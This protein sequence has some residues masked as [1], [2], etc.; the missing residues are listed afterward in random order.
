MSDTLEQVRPQSNSRV[1]GSTNPCQAPQ[2][3]TFRASNVVFSPSFARRSSDN[4]GIQRNEGA[5]DEMGKNG[6]AIIVGMKPTFVYYLADP[7]TQRHPRYVGM[8]SDIAARLKKHVG[9][10][11]FEYGLLG[12]WKKEVLTAGRI[13]VLIVVAGMEGAL[14]SVVAGSGEGC[15]IATPSAMV[16]TRRGFS[17]AGRATCEPGW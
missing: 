16:A 15:A 12:P 2:N 5:T 1:V 6:P 3:T 13:P 11:G 10:R 7:L 9:V 14:P 17:A 4:A 8:T